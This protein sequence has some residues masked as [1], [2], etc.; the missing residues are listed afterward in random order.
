[1]PLEHSQKLRLDR[2]A[3]LADLVQ[4]Q[5]SLVGG[6]ELAGLALGGTGEGALLVAEEFALEERL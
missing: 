3:H 6:L 5:C 1:M 4:K 2:R